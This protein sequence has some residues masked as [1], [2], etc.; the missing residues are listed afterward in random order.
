MSIEV[1]E[2]PDRWGTDEDVWEPGDGESIAGTVVK[3]ETAF[4]KRFEN[5]FEILHVKNGSGETIKVLGAR[6][7][8]A[9]LIEEH[10]PQVG[11]EVVIRHWSPLPGTRA[12]LYAMRVAK[13][14][15]TGGGDSETTPF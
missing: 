8:L 3:R 13:P 5:D 12:H 6:A 4:S 14:S 11:D 1:P 9:S 10:D 2:A 7:H 15:A